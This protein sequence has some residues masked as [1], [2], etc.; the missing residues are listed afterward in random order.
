[1]QVPAGSANITIPPGVLGPGPVSLP[2][3]TPAQSIDVP[4]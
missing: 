1:M 2:V 3:S 4:K